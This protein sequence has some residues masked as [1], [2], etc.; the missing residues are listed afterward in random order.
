MTH[1]VLGQQRHTQRTAHLLETLNGVIQ[2]D[3]AVVIKLAD[4]VCKASSRT[5]YQFDSLAIGE[6]VKLVEQSLADHKDVLKDPSV[7]NLLGDILDI[8]C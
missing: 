6:V 5:G 8:F 3:P 4:D 7:A 2:Y 1:G